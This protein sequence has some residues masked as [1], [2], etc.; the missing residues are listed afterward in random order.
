MWSLRRVCQVLNHGVLVSWGGTICALSLYTFQFEGCATCAWHA[1]SSGLE[2]VVFAWYEFVNAWF[3]LVKNL[4]WIC[5]RLVS[6]IWESDTAWFWLD[7]RLQPIGNGL[8]PIGIKRKPIGIK[9]E[10]LIRLGF[11]LVSNDRETVLVCSVGCLCVLF[12]C[13]CFCVR[14]SA[15]AKAL[16]ACDLPTS[17]HFHRFSGVHEANWYPSLSGTPWLSTP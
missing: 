3:W 15:Y 14:T 6:K 4:I 1:A 17:I 8:K 2:L 7:N 16:H 13:A 11:G 5:K 9:S 10:N 12:L